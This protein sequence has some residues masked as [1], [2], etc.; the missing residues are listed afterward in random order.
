MHPRAW[1]CA[2]SH[3]SLNISRSIP[4]NRPFVSQMIPTTPITD[5]RHFY[6]HSR[7]PLHPYLYPPPTPTAQ[8]LKGCVFT[9]QP[10]CRGSVRDNGR[11]QQGQSRSLYFHWQMINKGPHPICHRNIDFSS[12]PVHKK[13][14]SRLG[15]GNLPLKH[16]SLVR[17]L[18]APAADIHEGSPSLSSLS[19]TFREREGRLM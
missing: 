1:A 9:P 16:T 4:L 14:L 17:I 8:P 2:A 6:C 15:I 5:C 7:S 10:Q 18:W 13:P 12:A 19:Q 11:V 3:P